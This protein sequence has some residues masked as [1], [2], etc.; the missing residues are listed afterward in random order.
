MK[1]GI[2]EGQITSRVATTEPILV[3]STLPGVMRN[4]N[5]LF[6]GVLSTEHSGVMEWPMYRSSSRLRTKQRYFSSFLDSLVLAA[7]KKWFFPT[8][9]SPR[10]E[11]SLAGLVPH[12]FNSRATVLWSIILIE[13]RDEPRV[14][15]QLGTHILQGRLAVPDVHCSDA[16]AHAVVAIVLLEEERFVVV[17]VHL[18]GHAGAVVGHVGVVD[19]RDGV[20]ALLEAEPRAAHHEGDQTP[21][22]HCTGREII[23]LI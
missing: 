20:A 12:A 1:Y 17:A 22:A 4:L 16:E 9:Q 6:S 2:Y 23:D 13:H 19:V 7:A 11:N 21:M 15:V 10:H 5:G 3:I 14:L 18:D 8:N